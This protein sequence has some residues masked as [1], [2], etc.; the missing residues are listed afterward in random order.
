MT[1]IYD[2]IQRVFHLQAGD[3]SYV[4]QV[5]RDRYLTHR[6]WGKRIERFGDS[7]PLINQERQLS[8]QLDVID[9]TFS[10]DMLPQE[11][12]GFGTTDLRMP[13]YQ[14]RQADGSTTSEL[15][16]HSYQIIQGKPALA[17]L[18]ATYVENDAEAQTLV[19]ELRDEIIGLSVLLS[20]TVFEQY[21][22]ITRSV[23]FLNEGTQ[24]VTLQRAGSMSIDFG[25]NR[26]ELLHLSGAWINERNVVRRPVVMGNQSIESRR[27]ASSPQHNPFLALLR[28]GTTETHGE[29]YGFNLVYSGNF[30]G[31]VE[32]DQY[33]TTR[34]YLGLNPFDFG[35]RL[36]PG[37]SFQAPEVVLTYS[38]QG[39]GAMSRKFHRLYRNRL[40][41][42]VYR[43]QERPI[44]ANNWEATYFDF[45]ADKLEQLAV[46]GSELGI[47]L[48][49]LD[50]GWYGKR[51]DDRS[52]LGDW[53]VNREKLPGGLEEVAER[54][55]RQGLKFGLW[56]EPEMIS[57]DSD[58][59]RAHPDWCIH[60][61]N[62]P[63][64]PSRS[65]LV[66]DLSRSEVCEA[67]MK[68]LADILDN[69]PV[70]YIKWDM[71]RHMT[72]VGSV[73]LPPERQREVPHRYMLG[74]YRILEWLSNRYPSILMESCS[75]GGGRFDP[76]MLYYMPQTWTSDN[77]D[78]VSRLR[79]QY[80]TSI[81]YPLVAMG[82][83][84]SA[85]P[86]HQVGRITS[87]ETRGHTAFFG[88]LGYELD[89]TALSEEEMRAMKEQIELYKE[90]RPIVQFGDFYRLINPFE[91]NEAAW[92][93]VAEDG[94]EAVVGYYKVLARPNS[95]FRS[96]RLQG[97]EPQ[98]QYAV[99]G[100]DRLFGG[101]ELMNVGLR[102]PPE[103][104][105]G[106]FRSMLWRV[107]RK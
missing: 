67:V 1:I 11:Y 39:L 51:N 95:G 88:N 29:V 63:R 5:V 69:V 62:R 79:I 15:H 8:P 59:Y 90:I 68:M 75:S 98:A 64:S 17:G 87:I 86:N 71:N 94:S 35:W 73:A 106:D 54:V 4:M 12:P 47:E 44:L 30:L 2:E 82:A 9:R 76:G 83:H 102:V 74:L 22:V 53:F 107:I 81:V 32:V 105:M 26:F 78:A 40:C 42:G 38:D 77:S 66:L 103:L 80:G 84:V 14:V 19:I 25:D 28:P 91:G 49:V 37:E 16:Y 101:D 70:A 43:D 97:L 104:L 89:L 13:A 20:Y 55:A 58:L 24:A 46:K 45:D 93:T 33:E 72:E 61:P 3:T 56:L 41:R 27:G 50:D 23:R 21:G 48:L 18:P 100:Y 60:V 31:G 34:V 96:I 36:E 7:V 65:Q 85:V 6:Y 92:M 10:L 52:S 57:E 99:T